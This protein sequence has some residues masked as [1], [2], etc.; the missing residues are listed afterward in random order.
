V[1][2]IF[3]IILL[4]SAGL[5]SAQKGKN[6]TKI[7]PKVEPPLTEFKG[8]KNSEG[9][10]HGPAMFYFKGKLQAEGNYDNGNKTGAWRYTPDD[11]IVIT[12]KYEAGKKTGNWKYYRMGILISD[13]NYTENKLQGYQKTYFENGNP[14]TFAKYE[15]GDKDSIYCTYY[16][17]G[18]LKQEYKYEKPDQIKDYM[19]Y[20]EDGTVLEGLEYYNGLPYSIY[21]RKKDPQS[22]EHF[23]E[24]SLS[25]GSGHIYLSK[26]ENPDSLRKI[27]ELNFSE[28]ILNGA[29]VKYKPN[30]EVL[31]KGAF[32]NGFMS[33]PWVRYNHKN[34]TNPI[35]KTFNTEDNIAIDSVFIA[36]D[37]L[38]FNLPLVLKQDHPYFQG[39]DKGMIQFLGIK[40]GYPSIARE[41]GASG[42]I[43]VRF[44]VETDGSFADI[45]IL[46]MEGFLV[47]N[48]NTQKGAELNAEIKS[49]MEKCALNTVK[50]MPYWRPAFHGNM[51]VRVRVVVPIKFKLM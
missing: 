7:A 23:F 14:A 42:S 38:E 19:F 48:P 33:G 1:K 44:T 51:P 26:Q 11:T 49:E 4:C 22:G 12:G 41:N 9:K 2:Y 28:K 18:K 39:G 37:E 13:L 32:E 20:A 29:Y 34:N 25:R 8:S 31:S 3:T 36:E 47:G 5:I 50:Q 45:E 35:L 21:S 30:G 10:K 40:A 24:G 6:K 17:S 27:I 43:W 15:N 16:E 46:K